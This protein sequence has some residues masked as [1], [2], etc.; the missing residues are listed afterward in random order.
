MGVICICKLSDYR[1]VA[2]VLRG[3]RYWDHRHKGR[4]FLTQYIVLT[5]VD[6]S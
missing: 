1:P 3:L 4:D 5:R 2:F 6:I